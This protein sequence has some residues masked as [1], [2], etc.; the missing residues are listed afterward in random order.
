MSAVSGIKMNYSS[1]I[2]L[3][4]ILLDFVPGPVQTFKHEGGRGAIQTFTLPYN[5]SVFVIKLAFL[6]VKPCLEVTYTISE[7]PVLPE[8]LKQIKSSS[9]TKKKPN[10]GQ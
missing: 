4:L 5:R 6:F 8:C 2:I 7:L 10:R 9:I 1:A 3:T